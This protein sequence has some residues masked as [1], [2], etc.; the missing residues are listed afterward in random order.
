M[1]MADEPDFVVS[2]AR[3]ALL[4]SKYDSNFN[5]RREIIGRLNDLNTCF[6]CLKTR[7][8]DGTLVLACAWK[9]RLCDMCW[10]EYSV[11]KFA[12][13]LSHA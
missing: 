6:I 7:N 4:G 9:L 3:K 11:C 1:G 10:E 5:Y 2:R 8:S 12:F 13:R